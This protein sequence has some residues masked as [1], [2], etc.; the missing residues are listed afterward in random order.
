M[1]AIYVDLDGTLIRSDLLMESLL[2]TARAQPLRLLFV[3]WWL[4]RG[5]ACLKENLAAA[6]GVDVR[7]LP[8]R[9]ELVE[10][11]QQQARSGHRLILTTAA[12]ERLARAVA[13]HVALFDE[14]LASTATVNLKGQRKAAAIIEHSGGQQFWYAGNDRADLPVWRRAAGAILVDTGASVARQ[15]RAATQTIAEWPAPRFAIST[16]LRALR[17]YQWAKNFLVFVPLVTAHLWADAA[18]LRNAILAFIAVSLCASSIYVINDLLD[19][20]SDRRHPRKCRRPFASGALP[21]SHGLVV[22]PF[23]A[24]GGLLLASFVSVPFLLVTLVYLVTTTAYSLRLKTFV[25]LDV[26]ALACLYTVRVIAGAVAIGVVLSFWLLA[27]SMFMFLSLAL[28]K[29]YS[30]LLALADLQRVSASGRDYRVSD[31]GVVQSLGT[32]SGF[33]AVLVFALFIN[34]DAVSGAYTRPYFLWTLC[35]T[36]L[37]WISRMWLKAVRGEMHDDPLLYAVRDRAS[38]VM[39]LLSLAAVAVAV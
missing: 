4:L 29:R 9:A 15:A 3:P 12:N 26:M 6:G 39:L 30:E 31:L 11:L 25:L 36:L 38:I 23:L 32:A 34:S 10:W 5:R 27:F 14:T 22:A 21:I 28:V 8:Y 1:H 37:Y 35:G 33:A 18:A 16:W 17:A 13:S 24:A 19:L 20:P 2:A 7:T